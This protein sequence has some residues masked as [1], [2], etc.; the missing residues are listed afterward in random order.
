MFL[1]RDGVR[2]WY[3]VQG[4]GE[5][6]LL[7]VHG[8]LMSHELWR[9]QV[10]AFSRTHRVVSYDLRGFGRSD[11]PEGDYSLELF[12]D[13][14]DHLVRTLQLERPVL[15]GWSM[16][17]SIG[18]AYAA[19]HPDRLSKLVLVDGTPLLVASD[20]FAHAIPGA[21]ADQL[22]GAI[23]ADFAG[24]TRAFVE[25][26]FPEPDSGALKDWVHGITQ[27]TTAAVAL[28]S[29]GLIGG[30]DLRPLLDQVRIPTLV[31][32]GDQDQVCLPS[33][34]QFMQ[35]Q[36]AQ[37]EIQMFAGKGHA[38]FLTDVEAFNAQL[39]AFV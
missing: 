13:D 4:Q 36:I 2:H 20:D 24:G 37:A 21:A 18:L 22:L 23:Q 27:Q 34:S 38:P 16:G 28:N 17:A 1:E 12:V 19:A 30:R 8:W 26:M 11:K 32:C 29:I 33:A 35:R 25:L 14:L 7:F 31:V 10:A 3:D 5:Q 15:V 6:T 39:R 9:E